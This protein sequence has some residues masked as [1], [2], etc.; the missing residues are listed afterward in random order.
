M[1]S[2]IEQNLTVDERKYPARQISKATGGTHLTSKALRS[3]PPVKR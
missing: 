1:I 3:K 2:I